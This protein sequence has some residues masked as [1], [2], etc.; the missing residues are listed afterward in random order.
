MSVHLS[1]L[2]ERTTD[3]PLNCDSET[4]LPYWSVRVKPGAT[5]APPAGKTSNFN[6]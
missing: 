1:S 2:N 3:F 4:V 5:P 6:K